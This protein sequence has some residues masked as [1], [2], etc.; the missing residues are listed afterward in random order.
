MNGKHAEPEREG[1]KRVA[2]K[3]VMAVPHPVFE[4]PLPLGETT[5][6]LTPTEKLFVLSHLGIPTIERAAWTLAMAGLLETPMSLRFADLEQFQPKRLCTIHQCAGNPLEPTKPTR[7]IANVEWSGVLLRDILERCGVK[8]SCTYVWAFGADFGTF[9][10]PPNASPPQEHY[11]K[12]LPLDYVMHHDVIVATHLNGEPLPAKHGYPARL[13]VPGH[14]GHNSVKWLCR[15]EAADRR[16]DGYFTTELYTDAGGDGE[17]PRPAWAIAPE[18][19]IVSPRHA[20][21][22]NDAEIVVWGWAWS[23]TGVRS[24]DLTFDGGRSWV[25]ADVAPRKQASWQRF[26]YRWQVGGSGVY[27]L[28]SRATNRDGL[29]QPLEGARNAIHTVRVACDMQST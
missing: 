1:L 10:V 28:G 3:P 29:S 18:S 16:A 24:V 17:K 9:G 22:L 11:V 26:S 13:V 21:A 6:F 19:I 23:A 15:L 2:P 7:T 8:N 25:A 5:D 14:Y 20:S 4:F 27:V 12:D